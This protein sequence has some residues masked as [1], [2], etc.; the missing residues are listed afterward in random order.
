MS[1]DSKTTTATATA[2]ETSTD[3]QSLVK[4]E[5][6]QMQKQQPMN[7]QS[8]SME[9]VLDLQRALQAV[10]SGFDNFDKVADILEKDAMFNIIDAY[11]VPDFVDQTTGEVSDKIVWKLEMQDGG[12][13]K[14]C[15]QSMSGIRK[16]IVK[17]FEI[18]RIEGYKI[19][20]RNYKFKQKN[21]GKPSPA[22]IF[23][24]SK[25]VVMV[26]GAPVNI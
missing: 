1:K 23:D 6:N 22:T 2:E 3:D 25:R 17:L 4:P 7:M 12:D 21:T 26:N 9:N 20:L 18:G 24:D 8:G 11:T 10:S 14:Q 16:Q 19:E 15:M 5:Q 13:I